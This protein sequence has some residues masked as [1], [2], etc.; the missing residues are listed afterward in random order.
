[1][2]RTIILSLSFFLLIACGSDEM[3]KIL[4]KDSESLA[5]EWQLIE[6]KISSGGPSS[7]Q[8]VANG[9]TF[10]LNADGTFKGLSTPG[11]STNN[12]CNTGIYISTE[13]ELILNYNC[14]LNSEKFVY[15]CSTDN[16][17]LILS[18][19][20]VICFEECATKYR[21]ID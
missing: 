11:L 2:K 4:I 14:I 16:G 1:M 10:T 5:G 9:P 17:D 3:N 6:Q 18:P 13:E 12:N 19:T 21:K 8:K 15:A 7:W 20:T